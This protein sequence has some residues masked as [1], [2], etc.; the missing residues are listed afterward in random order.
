MQKP[1]R[2]ASFG[3]AVSSTGRAGPKLPWS[4]GRVGSPEAAKPRRCLRQIQPRRSRG[5]HSDR[6][7]RTKQGAVF[8]AALQFSQGRT[9]AR[10]ENWLSA[11]GQ[12]RPLGKLAKRKRTAV[13]IFKRAAPRAENL[14]NGNPDLGRGSR[15]PLPPPLG[16]AERTRRKKKRIVKG[17][18]T[19]RKKTGPPPFTRQGAGCFQ[20]TISGS[21]T[22]PRSTSG[23]CPR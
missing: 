7:L 15:N 5:K 6:V 16:P 21:C 22:F 14:G 20:G 4:L 8:G 2:C 17:R 12:R 10:W 1:E 11:R 3:P 13:Q 18:A 23:S 19:N 9:A